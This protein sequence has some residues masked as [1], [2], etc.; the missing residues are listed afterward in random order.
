MHTPAASGGGLLCLRNLLFSR[1]AVR[2]FRHTLDVCSQRAAPTW[3]PSL[4]R[5]TPLVRSP[6]P[7]CPRPVQTPRALG[8]PSPT[9]SQEA[10]LL[11]N[12]QSDPRIMFPPSSDVSSDVTSP[13]RPRPRSRRPHSFQEHPPAIQRA[14]P[15]QS[16]LGPLA[17]G[18]RP[19]DG[20]PEGVTQ[21]LQQP[22]GP[23]SRTALPRRSS[24]STSGPRVSG[25]LEEPGCREVSATVGSESVGHRGA[26]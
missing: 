9:P 24:G 20:L 12:A 14:V 17:P 13:K 1:Q 25:W 5:L 6:T 3:P 8:S 4:G 26:S 11:P 16:S 7:R 21:H 2:S 15:P 19:W 22:R 18:P 10:E 23:H